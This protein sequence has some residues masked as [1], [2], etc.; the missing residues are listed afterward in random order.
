MPIKSIDI[1]AIQWDALQSQDEIGMHPLFVTQA[2]KNTLV[3]QTH[4]AYNLQQ[5]KIAFL[6]LLLASSHEKTKNNVT[7]LDDFLNSL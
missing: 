2:G 1:N 5:E 3:I 6:T 7:S 4:E